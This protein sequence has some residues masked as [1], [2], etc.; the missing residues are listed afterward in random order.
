MYA[1]STALVI[2]VNMIV[3][4]LIPATIHTNYSS[5]IECSRIYCMDWIHTQSMLLSSVPLQ[6]TAMSYRKRQWPQRC[7]ALSTWL[8][9]VMVLSTCSLHRIFISK[10]KVWICRPS[11]S[12]L[13]EDAGIKPGSSIIANCTECIT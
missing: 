4:A 9:F 3:P 5:G 8:S 10:Q 6:C 13:S 2:T 7:S 11:D 1:E 12:T